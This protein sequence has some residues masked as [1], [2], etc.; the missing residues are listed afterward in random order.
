VYKSVGLT[1]YWFIDTENHGSLY[2][3]NEFIEVTTIW[4]Y[5]NSIII[6]IIIM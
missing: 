6:I 2:S 5:I 4:R 3:H 1:F